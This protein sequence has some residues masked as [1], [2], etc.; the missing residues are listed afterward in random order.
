M[1]RRAFL[2]NIA[3][4]GALLGAAQLTSPA[5]TPPALA[6]PK[7]LRWRM[8]LAIPKTLPIWGEGMERFTKI[9]SELS[10]GNFKIRVYG[11]GEL[12]PALGTFD[13]V[14]K[15]ELQ[16]GHSASYYWQ[17]KIPATPFFTGIPFGMDLQ[18][19]LA[20]ITAADGQALYDELMHPHGVQ[21]LPCGASTAQMSGWFKK[22]LKSPADLKGVKIRIPGLASKI[23]SKLG[24]KPVLIAGGEVFTSLSTGVIDAVEWVGPYHD[25]TMGFHRGAKYYYGSSWAEPGGAI[26]ELMINKKA[27]DELPEEYRQII[28]VASEDTTRWMLAHFEKQNQIYLKKIKDEGNVVVAPLPESI[29]DAMREASVP[30]L[31]EMV[32][33]SPIAKKIWESYSSFQRGAVEYDTLTFIKPSTL[34]L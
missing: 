3:S 22:E 21:C 27:W 20:W 28:R 12:V 34:T 13:A 14:K 5:L 24:A 31:R 1:K 11:A 10:G 7:K 29:L 15:G 30:V 26:L 16:M 19:A 2:K 6:L 25:Y 23:Y 8:A 9:V 18:D 17:G 33:S 32:K 4:G